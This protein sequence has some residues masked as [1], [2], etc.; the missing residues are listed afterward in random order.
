VEEETEEF[1]VV[2]DRGAMLRKDGF[3][4]VEERFERKLM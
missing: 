3:A 4:R 1:A 2:L